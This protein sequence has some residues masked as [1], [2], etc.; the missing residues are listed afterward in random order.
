MFKLIKTDFFLKR[1]DLLLPVSTQQAHSKQTSTNKLY[2]NQ[3]SRIH[4]EHA[5]DT[6][7][8]TL[9][10]LALRQKLGVRLHSLG[11]GHLGHATRE[12]SPLPGRS[13]LPVE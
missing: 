7:T 4:P 11:Q 2:F 8:D 1:Q 6:I 12:A 5:T 10:D 13:V 9:H 3:E